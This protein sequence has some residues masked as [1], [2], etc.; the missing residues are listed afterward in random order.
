MKQYRNKK[1][2]QMI[3]VI[4]IALFVIANIVFGSHTDAKYNKQMQQFYKLEL[5]GHISDIKDQHRGSYYIEI[6]T[7]GQK[8]QFNSLPIAW[9]VKKYHID[10]ECSVSKPLNSNTIIF[11]KNGSNMKL[12]EVEI[13]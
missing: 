9:E 12:C 3:V 10:I 8:Q 4:G 7:G 6:S 2:V 13:K 1:L 5:F 11:Y